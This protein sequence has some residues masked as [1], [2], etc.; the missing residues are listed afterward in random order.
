MN[1]L[2]HFFLAYP[3]KGHIVGNFIADFVKGKKYLN[4]PQDIQ[5]GII[6]HRKIDTFTDT[7]P[8]V[9]QSIKKIREEQGKFSPVVIDMF[10]D[11]FLAA[12]WENHSPKIKLETFTFEIFQVLD[13]YSTLFPE[14]VQAFYPYMK[15]GNWLLRYATVRGIG[16]SLKGLY[17]RTGGISNM[18]LGEQTLRNYY[19]EL[20]ADFEAFFPEL[21]QY[22]HTIKN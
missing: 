22:V 12:Y 5:E 8:T 6:M 21:E 20:K 4:Y 11:Y 7:H 2:A 16:S 13:Q 1:F 19:K 9:K 14:R 18:H 3:H 17:K 10:Y 15:N